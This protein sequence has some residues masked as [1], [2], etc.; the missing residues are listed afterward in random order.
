MGV[1]VTVIITFY[2]DHI[3][4]YIYIYKELPFKCGKLYILTIKECL[5]LLTAQ[6]LYHGCPVILPHSKGAS[7]TLL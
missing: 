5:F 7:Y 3:Y 4:I 1:D 6:H 2:E